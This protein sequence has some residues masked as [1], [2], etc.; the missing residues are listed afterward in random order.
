L[1]HSLY[2]AHAFLAAS[3]VV[4]EVRIRQMHGTSSVVGWS[5]FLAPLLTGLAIALTVVSGGG[6]DWPAWWGVVLAFA[7]SPLLWL[8][9]RQPSIRHMLWQGAG[10]LTMLIVLLLA[11]VVTHA[12]PFGLIDQPWHG[13]GV[14][15]AIA[16]ALLYLLTA[17]LERAGL[18]HAG[19]RRWAYAGLYLDEYF[20]RLALRIGSPRW[21]PGP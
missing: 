19:A 12:L 11:A 9:P 5:V 4:R 7:W 15:A 6:S 8:S 13:A 17:N 1:G 20:T 18:E 16:F 3:T 2:K 14:V 21:M 10:G